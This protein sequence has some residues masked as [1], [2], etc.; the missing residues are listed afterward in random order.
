MKLY[1][2]LNRV[3]DDLQRNPYC[4]IQIQRRLVPKEYISRYNIDNLWKYNLPN[5]WRLIYSVSKQEVVIISIV[6][7]WLSHKKYERKFGYG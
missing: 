7:E 3:F 2:W 4:G 1:E 6:I 5:A